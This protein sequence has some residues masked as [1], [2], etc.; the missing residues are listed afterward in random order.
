MELT[1]GVE[2]SDSR[3]VGQDPSQILC[4]GV[5]GGMEDWSCPLTGVLPASPTYLWLC[6]LL[7]TLH[8]HHP[9]CCISP[10]VYPSMPTSS[11][12]PT[13]HPALPPS[14][15]LYFPNGLSPCLPLVM[16]PTTHPALPPSLMLYFPNGLS[17]HAYL[18]L[19]PLLLTLHSHH[20][21]CC[22]SPMVYRGCH[23][24]GRCLWLGS[25]I[26]RLRRKKKR[27]S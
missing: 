17:P 24:A 1:C 3:R 18:W 10:M 27:I 12:A 4:G 15:M 16:P 9:W 19:C 23:E 21:W 14:L 5:Q 6:P 20:P 26:L 22:I 8:S 25:G 13:T 11:Y 2:Y 7:L